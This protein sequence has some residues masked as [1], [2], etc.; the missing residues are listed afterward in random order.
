MGYVCVGGSMLFPHLA[1][2]VG[3]RDTYAEVS[4]TRET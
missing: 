2:S 1:L 4:L 3:Y